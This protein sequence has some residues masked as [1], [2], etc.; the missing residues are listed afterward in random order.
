[1]YAAYVGRYILCSYV[2]TVRYKILAVEILA[3]VTK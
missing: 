2:A 3:N 1:M